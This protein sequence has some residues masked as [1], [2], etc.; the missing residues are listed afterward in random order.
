[1]KLKL[2]GGGG[3]SHQP[4][5]EHIKKKHRDCKL[6]IFFTD[7]YSDL[8]EGWDMNKYNF[9]KMFLISEGGTPE[10]LKNKNCKVLDLNKYKW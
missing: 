7:G 3:T 6:A 5:M 4:V 9:H 8:N 1:M 10:Q 2:H